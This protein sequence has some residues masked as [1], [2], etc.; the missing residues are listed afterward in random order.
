MDSAQCHAEFVEM[1]QRAESIRLLAP[2]SRGQSSTRQADT[3]TIGDP[4]QGLCERYQN[5]DPL[6]AGHKQVAVDAIWDVLS[7]GILS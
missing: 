5:C 3:N 4:P 1:S 6:P 7:L 2:R